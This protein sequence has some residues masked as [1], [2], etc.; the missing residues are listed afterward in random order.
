[1]Q[2]LYARTHGAH[3]PAAGRAAEE[4]APARRPGLLLRP[5]RVRL[6]PGATLPL[7]ECAAGNGAAVPTVFAVVRPGAGRAG[8][9]LRLRTRPG[10]A[11]GVSRDGHSMGRCRHPG[12]LRG[13][14]P[15]AVAVDAQ[16]RLRATSW[17]PGR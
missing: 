15:V 16:N 2:K 12:R 14:M 10:R 7:R 9:L 13:A 11:E 3:G 5:V 17:R 8:R 1:M 4:D 6:Q